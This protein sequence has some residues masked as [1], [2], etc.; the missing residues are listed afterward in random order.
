MKGVPMSM[1]KAEIIAIFLQDFPDL[2]IFAPKNTINE[3]TDTKLVFVDFPF[4]W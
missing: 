3:L 1:T 2:N 4:T